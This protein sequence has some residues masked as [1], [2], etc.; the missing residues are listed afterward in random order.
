MDE[1]RGESTIDRPGSGMQIKTCSY[2][3][4][5]R[6]VLWSETCFLGLWREES[7]GKGRTVM[8]EGPWV[9][10]TLN[11]ILKA[12]AAIIIVIIEKKILVIIRLF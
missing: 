5:L 12:M 3:L 1:Q 11:F 7:K 10:R 2:W 4:G 8:K 6:A 9:L